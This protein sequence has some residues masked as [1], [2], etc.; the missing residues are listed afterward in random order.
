VPADSP[1]QFPSTIFDKTERWFE[2]AKA[3]LLDQIP[4]RQGCNRCCIG[5]FPV[6]ILDREEIRRG[7]G[8]VPDQMR[9]EIYE[10]AVRQVEIV[11]ARIPQLAGDRWLDHYSDGEIDDMA[12]RCSDLPC[13]ALDTDGSCGIYAYRPLAC[14]SMGIP[15]DEA[16]LVQGACEIQ[17][18]VPLIRLSRVLRQEE[19]I[20][21]QEEEVELNRLHAR[22]HTAGEEILLPYTFLPE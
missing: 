5:S 11:E 13:P 4:C 15:T 19:N 2:R 17:T 18:S 9:R 6:T 1:S 7:L 8:I 12:S 16:G 20:L 3:S 21:T 14:R 22:L 10:K